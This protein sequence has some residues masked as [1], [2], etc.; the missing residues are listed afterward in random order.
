[1]ISSWRFNVADMNKGRASKPKPSPNQ[2]AGCCL[3]SAC[4]CWAPSVAGIVALAN[5]PEAE[6]KSQFE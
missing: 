3:G 5:A 4:Q 2:L 6:E 1:M